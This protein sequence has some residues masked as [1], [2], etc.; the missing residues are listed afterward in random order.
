[1]VDF[2]RWLSVAKGIGIGVGVGVGEMLEFS[3]VAG[4]LF[5]AGSFWK[6]CVGLHAAPLFVVTSIFQSHAQV[7][8][9]A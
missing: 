6:S 1:M 5:M 3:G 8:L 4:V 7:Y 9:A 2:G